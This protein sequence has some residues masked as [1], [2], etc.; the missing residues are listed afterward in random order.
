MDSQD[1]L[2]HAKNILSEFDYGRGGGDTKKLQFPKI[3]AIWRMATRGSH[4]CSATL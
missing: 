1:N 4:C 3:T 2:K